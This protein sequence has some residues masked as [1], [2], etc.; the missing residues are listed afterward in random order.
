MDV[1]ALALFSG[2]NQQPGPF[3]WTQDARGECGH[4]A[5]SGV[6]PVMC[7]A[8]ERREQRSLGGAMVGLD[9]DDVYPDFPLAERRIFE[10]SAGRMVNLENEEGDKFRKQTCWCLR[11][12]G[13]AF[14]E[15]EFALEMPPQA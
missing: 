5:P 12:F 6:V 13:A 15:P 11:K 14:G 1:L 8:I 10:P 9:V 7:L 3:Q 4:F 2:L